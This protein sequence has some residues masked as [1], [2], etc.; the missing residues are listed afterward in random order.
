MQPGHPL[1]R[2]FTD[3]HHIVGINASMKH[4]QKARYHQQGGH[5]QF[6]TQISEGLQ[7]IQLIAQRFVTWLDLQLV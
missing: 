6:K 2:N 5:K 4:V 1:Q 3:Q 7:G